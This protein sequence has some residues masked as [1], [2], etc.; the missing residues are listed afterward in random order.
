[1][2]DTDSDPTS[3]TS[4]L[5]DHSAHL[6]CDDIISGTDDVPILQDALLR[7]VVQFKLALA[8]FLI[9]SCVLDALLLQASSLQ[10]L[11]RGSIGLWKLVCHGVALACHVS[12]A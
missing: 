9:V 7:H 1:M 11:D 4:T 10:P 5:L 3:E 6:P 2:S 8:P 12:L